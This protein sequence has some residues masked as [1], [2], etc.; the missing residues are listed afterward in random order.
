MPEQGRSEYRICVHDREGG[1][2]PAGGA[3]R[4]HH[5]T[6]LLIEFVNNSVLTAYRQWIEDGKKMPLDEVIDVTNRIVLGGVNGFFR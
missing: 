6:D 3:C 5:G 2:I 1:S 4:I